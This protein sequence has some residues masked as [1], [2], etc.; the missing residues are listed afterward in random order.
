MNKTF[1]FHAAAAAA[2]GTLT[3]PFQEQIEVAAAATLPPGGG[4]GSA[5]VENFRHRQ[6]LSFKEAYSYVTGSHSE[7][8]KTFRTSATT[9]VAGLNILDVVT[10]DLVV[11]RLTSRKS[12]DESEASIIPLGSRF[13]NLRIAGKRVEGADRLATKLFTEL[14]TF[15]KIQENAKGSKLQDHIDPKRLMS[16]DVLS[17]SLAPNLEK[18]TGDFKGA[19]HAIHVEQFGVVRLAEFLVSGNRRRLTMLSV[20]LGCPFEGLINVCY[21]DENGS[22]SP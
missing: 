2:S 16:G 14:D 15:E 5:R 7:A 18:E 22:I 1:H 20:V 3:A 13:E 17:C 12:D 19:G 4:Y 6:I 9:V 11:A 8:N 21:G 10:A